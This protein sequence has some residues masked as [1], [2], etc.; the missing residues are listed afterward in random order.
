MN[1]ELWNGVN[2]F[3]FLLENIIYLYMLLKQPTSYHIVKHTKHRKL[4][5]LLNTIRK[6]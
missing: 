5:K 3:Q 6:E 4:L 2:Q 1:L